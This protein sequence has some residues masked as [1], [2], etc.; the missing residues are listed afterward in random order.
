MSAEELDAEA[1]AQL[2]DLRSAVGTRR[3]FRAEGRR[4]LVRGAETDLSVVVDPAGLETT[5]VAH[6][7]RLPF[8]ERVLR[9]TVAPEAAGSTRPLAEQVRGRAARRLAAAFP[10]PD[11]SSTG[12]STVLAWS[13]LPTLCRI[14]VPAE[15][16]GGDATAGRL[17]LTGGFDLVLSVVGVLG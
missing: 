8:L 9:R 2:R 6:R 5:V 11:V 4:V 1:T 3:V 13:D 7:V 10:S 17:A 12:D 15:A 16:G 14:S